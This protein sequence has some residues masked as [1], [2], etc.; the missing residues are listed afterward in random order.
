MKLPNPDKNE[1][2]I[3]RISKEHKQLL[4]QLAN[5]GKYGNNSSEVIRKLIVDAHSKR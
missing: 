4:E 5:S 2:F 1:V 3:M